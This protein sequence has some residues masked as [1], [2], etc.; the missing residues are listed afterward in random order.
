MTQRELTIKNTVWIDWREKLM[1]VNEETM[2]AVKISVIGVR[3][4]NSLL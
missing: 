1:I 3:Y 4:T 2:I